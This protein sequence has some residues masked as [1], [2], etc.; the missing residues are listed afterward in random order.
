MLKLFRKNK[1]F[2]DAEKKTSDLPIDYKFAPKE[3]YLTLFECEVSEGN[4]VSI[5]EKIGYSLNKNPI[6]SG[7]S[8]KVS[9]IV[10]ISDKEYR[11]KIENDFANTLSDSVIPFGKK[12][13]IKVTDLTPEILIDVIEKSS[14]KTRGK[15]ISLTDRNISQRIKDSFG[16]AKQIVINCVGGEPY[17]TSVARIL[18]ENSKDILT[19]MKIV[20]AAMKIGEGAI[21][22]DSENIEAAK[23]LSG[24]LKSGDNI[25]VV[26]SK[27]SYPADN[28][29]N[30]IYT[31]TSV[32][33]SRAKNVEKVKCVVFDIREIVSV[34]RAF[35]YGQRETGEVVTLSG[36]AFEKS[37]NVYIPYGTKISEIADYADIIK[38]NSV[39][40]FA[41]GVLRGREITRDDIFES[42][43][44]PI[45]A[46]KT[47]S[48]PRFEGIRCVRCA[49]C[50]RACP[51]FLMPMYLSLA[52]KL[53][54]KKNSKKLGKLFDIN[55]CTECGLCQYVC[56]SGIPILE[57]IRKIK[58]ADERE[59]S[60]NA[61]TQSDGGDKQ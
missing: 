51:M 39:K 3:I 12:N 49:E 23:I 34:A 54:T 24:K 35:V 20:M 14:V 8:G 58:N 15:Q 1:A 40:L 52:G 38:G 31:L 10:K 37:M 48:I 46:L 41:G 57:N 43:M 9:E 25:K 42:R 28:D 6:Y 2:Y 32:E 7:I 11:M 4:A 61:T 33:I 59:E 45:V 60:K 36:E 47:E 13:N 5:G 29:H 53:G 55:S 50:M 56:P 19:G 18:A 21:F 16:K 44:S 30:V 27:P 26:P 22:I 17:D